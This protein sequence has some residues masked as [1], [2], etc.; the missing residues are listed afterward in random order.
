MYHFS[1]T[2]LSHLKR[3]NYDKNN[4]CWVRISLGFL[5]STP[6]CWVQWKP[7][8]A[9]GGWWALLGVFQPSK[10]FAPMHPPVAGS[11]GAGDMGTDPNRPTAKKYAPPPAPTVVPAAPAA[12]TTPLT[13]TK[14]DNM[15]TAAS[16]ATPKPTPAAVIPS[17][18]LGTMSMP[19]MPRMS[20]PT[21]A[22]HPDNVQVVNVT[23]Q[24]SFGSFG[25]FLT[26]INK[27]VSSA[28]NNIMSFQQTT[29][30]STGLRPEHATPKTGVGGL[31]VGRT[32]S[33][34]NVHRQAPPP[35][36]SVAPPP[37][38]V[39]HTPSGG[40]PMGGRR[41]RSRSPSPRREIGFSAAVTNICDQAHAIME[42][43]RRPGS[44]RRKGQ[45]P[46]HRA[47]TSSCVACLPVAC[48]PA[49]VTWL[50]CMLCMFL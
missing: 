43:D 23:S 33:E 10:D 25:S 3:T 18:S 34:S 44:F 17:P 35:A 37:P 7:S 38:S 46:G 11:G 4:L 19:S 28:L 14:P 24:P 21:P 50:T 20:A 12:P 39:P 31:G 36:V 5:V 16:L 26:S 29:D 41:S 49:L 32:A 13:E 8:L 6:S 45:W 42:E 40:A 2:S 30:F 15:A 22:P 9:P 48:C 47:L 27:S 1:Y